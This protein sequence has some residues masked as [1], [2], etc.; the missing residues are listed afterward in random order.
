MNSL[1]KN[2]SAIVSFS[3]VLLIWEAATRLLDPG[4]II[5]PASQVIVT[6]LQLLVDQHFMLDV[7]HSLA[8]LVIGCII[9]IS[10]GMSLGILIGYYSF[11]NRYFFPIVKFTITIPKIALLPLFIVTLGIGETSKITI[12]ALGA[13]FPMLMTTV[14]SVQRVPTDYID[15]AQSL[16]IKKLQLLRLI[17]FPY[18]FPAILNSGFRL[19]ISMGLVLLVASEMISARYGL[20]YF[21]HYTGSDL[22]LDKMFAG[23][24]V[25]G[26]LGLFFNKIIDITYK[27]FCQW[28]I[29]SEGHKNDIH[30]F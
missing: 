6:L 22:S 11:F 30:E 15:A 29:D 14:A 1:N 19:S 28:A 16:G 20:G 26:G 7:G 5:P 3:V 23:V 2:T 17:V 21:I 12:V 13:F 27:K 24:F 10:I 18:A 25:L 4:G 9:G 8:R